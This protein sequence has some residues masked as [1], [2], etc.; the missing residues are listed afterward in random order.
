[1]SAQIAKDKLSF[2]V[3][4]SIGTIVLGADSDRK[5]YRFFLLLWAEHSWGDS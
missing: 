5:G 1:M 2:A 3:A 4:Q